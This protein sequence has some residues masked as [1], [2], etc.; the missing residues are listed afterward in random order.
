MIKIKNSRRTG[1]LFHYAHFICDCLFTEVVNDIFMYKIVIREKNTNQTIGNFYKIYNEVMKS[2]NRELLEKDFNKLDIDTIFL[3]KDDYCNKINFEKSISRFDLS[4]KN[5]SRF[6]FAS[7]SLFL[8]VIIFLR[9]DSSK[10]F[11]MLFLSSKTRKSYISC[12]ITFS[13]KY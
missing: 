8:K 6:L 9:I 4:L 1:S 11:V 7:W 13:L 10:P 2:E 3:N 5:N 12:S